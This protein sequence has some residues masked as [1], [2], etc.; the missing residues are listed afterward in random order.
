MTCYYFGMD[1]NTLLT[2]PQVAARLGY[3]HIWIRRL[4][5]DRQL[6]ATWVGHTWIIRASDVDEFERTHRT[7][8]GRP[9][10]SKNRTTA[11]AG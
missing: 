8:R 2:V 6:P 5:Y 1:T 3:S 10:G 7:T 9:P 4:I 11:A